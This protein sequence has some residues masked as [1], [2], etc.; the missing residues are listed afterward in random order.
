MLP[1]P[2]T[3]SVLEALVLADHVKSLDLEGEKRPLSNRDAASQVVSEVL[4][5]V[6][7]SLELRR[8]TFTRYSLFFSSPAT[9]APT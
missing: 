3:S 1:L 4:A 8:L 5:K 6:N 2:D 9:L 7:V